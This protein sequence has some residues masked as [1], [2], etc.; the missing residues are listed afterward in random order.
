[1]VAPPETGFDDR[2]AADG[3][4]EA[5]GEQPAWGPGLTCKDAA[6]G[7]VNADGEGG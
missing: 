5:A 1:M 6:A 3:H 2:P 4:S 7:L